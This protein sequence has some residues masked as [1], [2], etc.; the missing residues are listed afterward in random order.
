MTGDLSTY[1]PGGAIYQATLD[2]YGYD[3]AQQVAD[4]ALNNPDRLDTIFSDLRRGTTDASYAPYADT[5]TLSN[6]ATQIVTDPLAAPLDYANKALTNTAWSF[7][8]NPMVLIVGAVILFF[9]FGGANLLRRKL[10]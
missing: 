4:A 6:F 5:S 3:A 1:R 9:V 10:Q 7:L 8:R 2:R